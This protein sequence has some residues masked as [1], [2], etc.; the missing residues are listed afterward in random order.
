MRLVLL[1]SITVDFRDGR[2][3]PRSQAF[4]QI[5]AV[6]AEL[7]RSILRVRARPGMANTTAKGKHI[8]RPLTTKE[9]ISAIFYKHYPAFASGQMDVSELAKICGLSRPTVYKYLKLVG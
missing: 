2:I 3:D 7:E 6:F 9:G 8:G 5:P 4:I 1:G